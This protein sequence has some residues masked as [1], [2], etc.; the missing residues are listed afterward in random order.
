M[1]DEGDI[2]R[3]L[4]DADKLLDEVSSAEGKQENTR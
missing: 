4:R 3:N 2:L 1:K